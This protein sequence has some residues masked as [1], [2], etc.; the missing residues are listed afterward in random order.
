MLRNQNYIG[1]NPWYGLRYRSNIYG[2]HDAPNFLELGILVGSVDQDQD[3]LATFI[4]RDIALGDNFSTTIRVIHK[5]F[6]VYRIG[7]NTLHNSVNFQGHFTFG[8]LFYLSL[9]VYYKVVV[10]KS[11]AMHIP[12]NFFG[13]DRFIMPTALIGYKLYEEGDY[14]LS[15]DLNN[16]DRF[17]T[18]KIHNLGLD[19]VYSFFWSQSLQVDCRF[20]LRTG[21]VLVGSGQITEQRGTLSLNWVF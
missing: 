2:F 17:S 9:G 15:F 6:K 12:F 14:A 8:H 21:G 4:R 19:I 18:Y 10:Y 13:H 16:Y 5:E 1:A 11:P 3:T 7:E 20:D